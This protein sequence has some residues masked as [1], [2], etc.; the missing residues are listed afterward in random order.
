M[1]LKSTGMFVFIL[2]VFALNIGPNAHAMGRAHTTSTGTTAAGP[3]PLVT[4][5]TD[6]NAPLALVYN[7]PGSCS[8]SEGDAGSTGYGCSE[9]SADIASAAGF[10]VQFVGP[11]DLSAS[12][13]TAE[14][15]AIFGS[16]KVWLQP[17]GIAETAISS[18]SARLKTELVNFISN[19]G[20]YVGTCAGAFMATSTVGSSSYTGL[21]IFP[22]HTAP[23]WYTPIKY[24]Y[25]LLEVNWSGVTRD[26]YFEGGPYIYG[27]PS[28]AQATAHF[29][30]GNVA[31]ARATYGKGRVY[32]SGPH[33]E[34]PIYWMS[35]DGVV[36][37]DGS[38]YMLG[39]QMVNWAAGLTNE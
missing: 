16:A 35:E 18:M 31:A 30:D 1:G 9:A 34:A 2:S 4:R 37:P 26:I 29:Q 24:D 19:G 5:I 32:I 7:G 27:L 21:N 17:G 6:P 36:D 12:S 28:T 25:T 13:T 38:D 10:R 23:Y 3:A 22:G 11:T 33:V 20:G 39:V 15:Q 14:V 8:V